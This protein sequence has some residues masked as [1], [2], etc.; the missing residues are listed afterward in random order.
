MGV[1]SHARFRWLAAARTTGFLGNAVAPIALSFAV[2]DLTG[3]VGDL[4]FVVGVRAIANVVLLLA[5]GVLADRLPRAL[6][7]QGSSL[8]AAATAALMAASV[9]A[10]FASVPLLAAIGLVNGA[11]AAVA[12]PASYSITPETVPPEQLQP[13]NALLRIGTNSAAITGASLGGLLVASAGPGWAM[14]AV[15]VVFTLE[16]LG[17]VRV[18]GERVVRPRAN[19]LAEL[20]EGWTEFVSRSW[21]W[22]VVLQFMIVNAA[23]V[24][25][26]QVLGPVVADETFGRAAWGLSLACQTAGAVVGG[27]LAAR[28]LPRRALL[29]GVA[30]VTLAAPPLLVLGVVPHLAVLMPAM[31]LCGLALEQFTIAW[32]LSLQEN[33]PGDRLA[34]VYSYDMIG[35]YIAVPV[36]GLATG[37]IASAAGTG[38]TLV[39]CAVLIVVTTLVALVSRQIRTLRRGSEVSEPT[40]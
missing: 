21:V 14:A 13:A 8:A 32:D 18:G 34:R 15:A 27:I 22:V 5:G 17:Y 23:V 4:G 33:V 29:F 38:P 6:L 20:R 36:G 19:P 39:G 35:S 28:W 16:A 31:F 30:L 10:G 37:P 7:L 9:V 25:G 12:L 2:L 11:V 26:A 1:L 3:S 24:G 40:P